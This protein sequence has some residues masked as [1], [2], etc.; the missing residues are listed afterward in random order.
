MVGLAERAGFFDGGVLDVLTY[1]RH[2]PSP[3]VAANHLDTLGK[4]IR[5]AWP[6]VGVHWSREVQDRQASHFN[7]VVGGLR[8]DERQPWFRWLR[9]NWIDITGLG[10]SDP[11]YRYRFGVKQER[12]WDQGGMIGYLG[13]EISKTAQKQFCDPGVE[14]GRWW[15]LINREVMGDACDPVKV[16]D[17]SEPEMRSRF[18]MLAS[19][20]PGMWVFW[21]EKGRTMRTIRWSWCGNAANWLVYGMNSELEKSGPRCRGPDLRQKRREMY[22]S[23][24]K[25]G[26][27]WSSRVRAGV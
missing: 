2:A 13:K 9:D 16:W 3:D 27:S 15:G 14:P 21:R 6:H 7:L 18:L 24:E 20:W 17:I 5:R 4:R 10:G 22:G 12:L 23:R 26:G 8:I 25:T 11:G 1:G 19:K